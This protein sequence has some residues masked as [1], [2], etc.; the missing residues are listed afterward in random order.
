MTFG[1]HDT[2]YRGLARMEEIVPEE[3]NLRDIIN[4]EVAQVNGNTIENSMLNGQEKLLII[5][6]I[7]YI[8][9]KC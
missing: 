2:V 5:R 9:L 8:S 3:V 6:K 1:R 7:L 4:P